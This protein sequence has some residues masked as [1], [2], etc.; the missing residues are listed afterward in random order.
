MKQTAVATERKGKEEWTRGK[1]A[2]ETTRNP[3]EKEEGKC[4]VIPPVCDQVPTACPLAKY[5][6]HYSG[7]DIP[8]TM[9]KT[10][11][12]AGGGGGEVV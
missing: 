9:H 4:K 5:P 1:K 7:R 3:K 12:G 6:S 8:V 10:V 2:D 11:K